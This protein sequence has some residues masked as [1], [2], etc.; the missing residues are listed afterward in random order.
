V[1]KQIYLWRST[2]RTKRSGPLTGREL[3]ATSVTKLMHTLMKLP[4]PGRRGK[5][6][7]RCLD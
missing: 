7:P 6:R 2:L 1:V 5:H 3:A 4:D